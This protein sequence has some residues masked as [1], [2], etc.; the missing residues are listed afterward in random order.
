[1][2]IT[3][4]RD[5]ADIRLHDIG[6]STCRPGQPQLPESQ[7]FLRKII[8]PSTVVTSR[9]LT[10]L[11]GFFI[12]L[13]HGGLILATISAISSLVIRPVVNADAF[14]EEMQIGEV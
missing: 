4:G 6:A 13:F 2:F 8:K 14:V 11:P 9:W 7:L 12:D 5:Y 3:D 10:V 1:M